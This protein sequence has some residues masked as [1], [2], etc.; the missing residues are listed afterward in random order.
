MSSREAAGE[1][2][3]SGRQEV[4]GTETKREY[5]EP[6]DEGDTAVTRALSVI[7]GSEEGSALT[8]GS[9]DGN[10]QSG[11]R[12]KNRGVTGGGDRKYRA[13]GPK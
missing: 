7:M 1:G 4:G 13:S 2:G 3:F 8:L 10:D 11:E 12:L 5:P 9:R 6:G